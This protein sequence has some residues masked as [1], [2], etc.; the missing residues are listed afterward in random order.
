MPAGTLPNILITGT[1]GTGKTTVSKEVSERSSLNYISI[2]E[3]AK[4]GELY[5]GYDEANECYILDEDRIVD[6]LEDAMSSGGQIIDYH[7]CEFFPE[8]WFDAVFV[9][10]T[11]NTILYPRLTSRDY[12][13]KKVSDLIHCEIV[14]FYITLLWYMMC[15]REYFERGRKQSMFDK[16]F[17]QIGDLYHDED[18]VKCIIYQRH[19]AYIAVHSLLLNKLARQSI[20]VAWS[21]VLDYMGVLSNTQPVHPFV[22]IVI[23]HH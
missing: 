9:L 14:Q 22:P 16:R 7:S 18:I 19:T 17:D 3:V 4:E 12:S 21:S 5:D 1:P 20:N 13:S 11:D 6:E 15:G 8:R 23:K 10:R 2:N